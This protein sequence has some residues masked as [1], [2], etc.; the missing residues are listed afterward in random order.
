M[1]GWRRLDV[2]DIKAALKEMTNAGGVIVQ[3]ARDVGGG[4]LIAQVKDANGNVVDC[5]LYGLNEDELLEQDTS[6]RRWWEMPDHQGSIR[7]ELDD[8]GTNARTFNYD[9]FGNPTIEA[10]RP[11]AR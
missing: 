7:R 6:G 4:L 3:D 2:E 8:K 1:I 9:Q 11:D 5:Y 10:A